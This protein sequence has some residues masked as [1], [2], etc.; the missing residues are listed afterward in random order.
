M[1]ICF[2]ASVSKY[3]AHNAL[4]WAVQK[5]HIQEDG[6]I[7]TNPKE[8]SYELAKQFN[9]EINPELSYKKRDGHYV[10]VD[11][12]GKTLF[13]PTKRFNEPNSA[14]Y[15]KVP[16]YKCRL[17]KH[18]SYMKERYCARYVR[19]DQ[20]VKEN[21]KLANFE[22]TRWKVEDGFAVCKSFKPIR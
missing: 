7:K 13:D 15:E 8:F 19:A 20:E 12:S 21:G 5:G 6:F 18:P 22:C 14:F 16:E 4:E 17:W 3:D 9:T 10:V 11:K 1:C 2:I